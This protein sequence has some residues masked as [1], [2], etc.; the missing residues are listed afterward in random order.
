MNCVKFYGQFF[1]EIC[2][3]LHMTIVNKNQISG[4]SIFELVIV[5]VLLGIMSVYALGSFFDQDEIA[6]RGFL[7]IP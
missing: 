7:T 5:I 6:A 3:R 1:Y 4:F 2:D